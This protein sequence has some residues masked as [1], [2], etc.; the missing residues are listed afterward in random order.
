M[1][2]Y[3]ASHNAPPLTW[4]SELASGAQTWADACVFQHSHISGF[5]ENLYTSTGIAN[6]AASVR[7]NAAASQPRRAAHLPTHP[8]GRL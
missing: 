1:L 3:R 6:P 8:I 5:G 7:A 2:Q 4:S